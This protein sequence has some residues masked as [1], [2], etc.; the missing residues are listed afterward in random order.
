M[1]PLNAHLLGWIDPRWVSA[2]VCGLFEKKLS[3]PCG[4]RSS[5]GQ[6][7][8]RAEGDLTACSLPM[9]WPGSWKLL[10]ESVSGNPRPHLQSCGILLAL[11]NCLPIL[12]L[13][14]QYLHIFKDTREQVEE[15]GCMVITE[16]HL[17]PCFSDGD[18]VFRGFLIWS[19]FI[20]PIK[21]CQM[22]PE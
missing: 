14:I 1:W 21:T 17:N 10:P 22:R 11:G 13:C 16:T 15:P 3:P 12:Y 9:L 6:L 2:M 5:P 18:H 20:I 7:W 8:K 4:L 19:P